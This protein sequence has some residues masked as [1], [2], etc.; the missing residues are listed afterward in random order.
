MWTTYVTAWLEKSVELVDYRAPCEQTS[1]LDE[2]LSPT[3][4]ITWQTAGVG[5][6]GVVVLLLVAGVWQMRRRDVT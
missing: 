5:L 6:A 4:E 3:M 1:V 2:C